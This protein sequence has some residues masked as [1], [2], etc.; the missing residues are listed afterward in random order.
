MIREYVLSGEDF[1]A[2][3]NALMGASYTSEAI[4]L[5]PAF[6]CIDD[7]PEDLAEWNSSRVECGLNAAAQ[8]CIDKARDIIERLRP[9]EPE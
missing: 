5:L 1:D 2:L 8:V 3:A 7:P 6:D 4:A 9:R